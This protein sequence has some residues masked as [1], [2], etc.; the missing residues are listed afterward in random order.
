M[1]RTRIEVAERFVLHQIHFA[2]EFDPDLVGVAMIDR[3][4][5]ADDVA[6]RTPDQMDVVL[7]EPFA[8]ALNLRPVLYLERDV[9]E[10]RDLVEDEVD[11]MV[12]GPATQEREGVAMPIRHRNP[13]TSV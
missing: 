1:P 10:L 2:E 3:D 9:V 5:V 8:G 11:G 12:I 4:V 6:P 13:S 7:G